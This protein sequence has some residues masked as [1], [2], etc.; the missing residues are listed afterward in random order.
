MLNNNFLLNERK[1]L[2]LVKFIEHLLYA[3][4]QCPFQLVGTYVTKAAET[5]TVTSG[6]G[7]T[8]THMHNTCLCKYVHI[9]ASHLF[10]QTP[11]GGKRMS[12]RAITYLSEVT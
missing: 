2:K 1:D 3:R 12:L 4:S 5:N 6:A 9:P 8:H 11:L 10:S 7:Q